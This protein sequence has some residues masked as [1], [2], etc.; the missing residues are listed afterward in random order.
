MKRRTFIKNTAASTA[1][2]SVGGIA[3]SS[4][5]QKVKQILFYTP[6]MYTATSTLLG[7]MMDEM[8][9]KEELPEELH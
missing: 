9:T 1:L 2:L 4:T 3:L 5:E 6:M 7:Q 8:P